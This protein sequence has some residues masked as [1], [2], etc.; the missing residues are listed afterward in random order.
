MY[1]Y[2]D[3]IEIICV[4]CLRRRDLLSESRRPPRVRK[5]PSA[6]SQVNGSCRMMQEQTTVMTGV[7]KM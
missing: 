2:D 1:R 7:R 5:V 3:C 6:V 4:Q